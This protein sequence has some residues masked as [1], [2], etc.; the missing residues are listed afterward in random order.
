MPLAVLRFSA[1]YEQILFAAQYATF[2]ELAPHC[3]NRVETS[4]YVFLFSVEPKDKALE[5]LSATAVE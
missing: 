3:L 4:E 2:Y 1:D 5:P